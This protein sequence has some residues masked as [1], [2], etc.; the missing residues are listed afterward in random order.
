MKVLLSSPPKGRS[1]VP[2][3][4]VSIL[5]VNLRLFLLKAKFR[6]NST[7]K[8][9]RLIFGHGILI[10]LIAYL[11]TTPTSSWAPNIA[12]SALTS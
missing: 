3:V 2:I 5:W 9:Q 8:L 6:K 7:L 12:L 1:K 10:I 4:I 11:P